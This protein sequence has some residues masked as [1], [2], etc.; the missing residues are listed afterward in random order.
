MIMRLWYVVSDK[1]YW[2]QP[3][4]AEGK[5]GRITIYGCRLYSDGEKYRGYWQW[6]QVPL[7]IQKDIKARVAD[8]IRR[9]KMEER[10]QAHAGLIRF[11]EDDEA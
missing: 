5:T 10:R 6:S 4:W 7:A 8:H 1:E 3:E 9:R 2:L 11:L